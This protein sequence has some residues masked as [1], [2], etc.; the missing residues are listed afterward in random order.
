M[1]ITE[2]GRPGA[3]T[4]I[5]AS[6]LALEM[7]VDATPTEDSTPAIRSLSEAVIAFPAG[8]NASPAAASLP[9]P[10]VRAKALLRLPP[11]LAAR[12]A[13]AGIDPAACRASVE[14]A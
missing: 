1:R 12:S 9:R 14:K 7:C 13:R 10:C 6:L 4:A 11:V 2:P 5:A 3:E 8:A